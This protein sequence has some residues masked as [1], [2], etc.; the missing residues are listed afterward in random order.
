MSFSIF[1]SIS[2]E[3]ARTIF[4]L[5]I[6]LSRLHFILYNEELLVLFAFICFF[7]F[8][9]RY[10]SAS[11]VIVFKEIQLQCKREAAIPFRFFIEKFYIFFRE[12]GDYSFNLTLFSIFVMKM[13]RFLNFDNFALW[14]K[15][16]CFDTYYQQEN[17]WLVGLNQY[18]KIRMQSKQKLLLNIF[19]V[20]V[21][22]KKL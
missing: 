22:R 19:F 6:I 1:S 3:Q 5:W 20:L 18:T 7:F 13:I 2:K 17:F 11:I 8:V 16:F 9:Y 12:S 4:I 21:C 10:G 14:V 15:P